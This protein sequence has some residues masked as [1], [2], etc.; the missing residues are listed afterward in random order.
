MSHTITPENREKMVN[1]LKK[2]GAWNKGIK[3]PKGYEHCGFQKGNKVGIGNKNMLGKTFKH[4]EDS[5]KKLSLARKNRKG[6]VHVLTPKR[7][8]HIQIMV[9]QRMNIIVSQEEKE[10]ILKSCEDQYKLEIIK[11]E[12]RKQS[13]KK[14]YLKTKDKK[15]EYS[16]KYKENNK[17][18]YNLYQKSRNNKKRSTGGSFTPKEWSELK[19]KYSNTCLCCLKQEPEIK[20]TADHI[21][22]VSKGGTSYIQNI[23]PLCGSCN[24]KKSTSIINYIEKYELKDI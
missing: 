11:E 14:Y 17:E 3:M 22:P 6:Y 7:L 24:S 1:G 15:K 9:K 23:Q 18:K 19:N 2:K 16:K 8:A 12:K 20:L 10:A 5:K 21:I 4:T 13:R